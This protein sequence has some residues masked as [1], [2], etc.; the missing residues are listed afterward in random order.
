MPTVRDLWD[1]WLENVSCPREIHYYDGIA[2]V[3]MEQLSRQQQ[4]LLEF[5]SVNVEIGV[6]R[7]NFETNVLDRLRAAGLKFVDTAADTLRGCQDRFVADSQ[8][9][10]QFMQKYRIQRRVTPQVIDRCT[11]LAAT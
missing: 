3:P 9:V 1:L 5:I 4:I 10:Q 8:R 2:D 6:R 11:A 7:W